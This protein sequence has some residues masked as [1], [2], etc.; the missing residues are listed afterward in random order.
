MNDSDNELDLN[1]ILQRGQSPLPVVQERVSALPPGELLILKV[2]FEPL[3][4][5]SQLTAW[6]MRY[7]AEP[8]EEG[9][10]IEV[11][12]NPIA[13]PTFLDLRNLPPPEPMQRTLEAFQKLPVGA[14]LIVHLPH[15]PVPLLELLQERAISWEEQKQ[16]DGSYHIYL[17]KEA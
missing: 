4:L 9:F 11:E 6:G 5:Y 1:L 14:C 12:R 17:L 3:P 7:E 16:S 8:T 15:R 2:A 10:R 13:V